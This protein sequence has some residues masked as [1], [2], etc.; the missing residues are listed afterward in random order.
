MKMLLASLALVLLA[1]SAIAQDATPPAPSSGSAVMPE[2]TASQNAA[3]S[4]AM[5]F[6]LVS[7]CQKADDD[8]GASY[9]DMEEGGGKEFFVRT[10]AMLMDALGLE[11][12]QVVQ[13]AI[14][15]VAA[16]EA[17]GEETVGRRMTA[18]LPMLIPPGS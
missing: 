1:P 17:E 18:C 3:Y 11:R 14:D 16:A 13:M 9:P 2:L 4:C 6:A 8:R 15:G 10:L 7:K 5:T 12:Q